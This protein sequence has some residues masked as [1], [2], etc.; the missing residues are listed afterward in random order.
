MSK[1]NA[2]RIVNLNYNRNTMKVNDETLEFRGEST[3]IS[4]RNGGG[5]TVMVQMMMAPFVNARFRDMKDRKFHDY[6]TSTTPTYILTEWVMDGSSSYVTVGMG[7]RKRPSVGEEDNGDELEIITFI[8]EYKQANSY[9]IHS[10]PVTEK[11]TKGFKVRSFSAIKDMMN[12]LKS[13]KRHIFDFYELNIDS[14]RRKYFDRLRQYNINNREWE[15]IIKKINMK[16][17]GLSE[18]FQD[19]KTVGGLFE[20]WFIPAVDDKLNDKDNKIKNAQEIMEKFIFQY[21][22]NEIKL[23]RKLGIQHFKDATKD[24]IE[25]AER[26]KAKK[27]ETEEIKNSIANLYGYIL[28]EIEKLTNKKEELSLNLEKLKGELGEIEYERLSYEYNDINQELKKLSQQIDDIKA[29]NQNLEES[30][31]NGKR[32]IVR[33]ECIKLYNEYTEASER[34]QEYEN[35]IEIAK[36][37]DRD[38][39]SERNNIGYTLKSIY[40]QKCSSLSEAISS[41]NED[42]RNIQ[43]HRDDLKQKVRQLEFQINQI[44]KE[45]ASLKEKI[46]SYNDLEVGFNREFNQSLSRNIEGEYDQVVLDSYTNG[47]EKRS[48]DASISLRQLQLDIENTS[49]ELSN[50]RNR[51]EE[52]GISIQ[53]IKNDLSQKE[54]EK[55]ETEACLEEIRKILIYM[56]IGEDRLYQKDYICQ[57]IDK[58]ISALRSEA[59]DLV[60]RKDRLEK[61][62]RMYETGDNLHLS[63]EIKDSL[64]ELGIG[65]VFGFEWLK[66]Q[67]I[68]QD[69]KKELI[70]KNP[71]LPYSLIMSKDSI[72]K[73]QSQEAKVFTSS[74]V[75]IIEQDRLDESLEAYVVNNVYTIG[76]MRY[77]IHFNDKLLDAEELKR[78]IENISKEIDECQ[79]L[80][81]VKNDEIEKYTRDKMFVQ[82]R[83]PGRYT[84]ENL[85][86]DIGELSAKIKDNEN[87][88]LKLS[89][90]IKLLEEKRKALEA[91]ER[92]NEKLREKLQREGSRFVELKS[93]Y[94]QYLE[95]KKQLSVK[96]EEEKRLYEEKR[97]AEGAIDKD[98]RQLKLISDQ[99]IDLRLMLNKSQDSLREYKIF[100]Q[101]EIIK[102]DQDDLEARYS[103][104]SKDIGLKVQEYQNILSGYRS[105]FEEK[106]QELI[107]K[108]RKNNIKEEEYRDKYFD[109]AGLDDL[110]TQVENMEKELNSSKD[111][112]GQM[113]RQ[114]GKMESSL[115]AKLSEIQSLGYDMPKDVIYITSIDFKS[116]RRLKNSE[117]KDCESQQKA[118]DEDIRTMDSI[119]NMMD[120]YSDFEVKTKLKLELSINEVREEWINLR[121]SYSNNLSQERAMENELTACCDKLFN[122]SELMQDDFFKNTITTLSE[123]KTD[124]YNVLYT[125]NTVQEVHQKA[126]QQLEI[127]LQKVEE[128]K[129]N[130]IDMFYDYVMQVHEHIA[131]IDDGSTIKI[132][133]R[134]LKMLDIIQPAWEDNAERYRLGVR[135][136]VESIIKQCLDELNQGHNIEE[137]IGKEITTLKLYDTVVGLNELDVKLYKIE[138]SRQVRISWNQVAVNSG[139]EGFLSAFV[140][141]SS[142]LSYMRKEESDIFHSAEEGKVIIMDNPFAQTNAEHLLKPL[143]DIARKNNTQ[144][145]C[146]T[147]LGGDSIY[148]RFDNIYVLSLIPSRLKSGISFLESEHIKGEE[149]THVSSSRFKIK[150][151]SVEQIRLF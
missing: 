14:Q 9:D 68:S 8:H 51:K 93:K 111:R 66:Q 124:P 58:R 29:F 82:D 25:S 86:K 77:F 106:E 122:E 15:S 10:F 42:A 23:K 87:E 116:R 105:T 94:V 136:M 76:A 100:T 134:S 55:E 46:S 103:A 47:F 43:K 90:K 108:S 75:P 144:L 18:L 57:Q 3:L 127:D 110:E 137:L 84:L 49:K 123:I 44:T 113:M 71:F 7:V 118:N 37:K 132:N 114:Q 41:K 88:S 61:E 145:I 69:A 107:S 139:G 150:Q 52:L 102:K 50:A 128:E 27:D 96:D 109:K 98:E 62:K 26:F 147:G 59:S 39:E 91:A 48:N 21:K 85:I 12:E 146:F 95:D 54:K 13:D 20:K 2:V 78:L 73:L 34:V 74:P 1:I 53:K 24:I 31:K 28:E 60:G 138:A 151:E 5:K 117:I 38:K 81:S 121:D 83:C 99:L 80:I 112:L 129:K 115:E 142:L 126:L 6:F 119:K 35:L 131:R 104:L 125:L 22:E 63:N 89:E 92:E 65:I 56:G 149:I 17:S 120:Q 11:T 101:G 40:E 45:I 133:D 72:Y 16:E 135:D 67:G 141:L 36:E 33:Q 140:I 4:L 79:N 70:R 130:I 30:I 148:N 19:A 143:M 32:E 97:E 64:K